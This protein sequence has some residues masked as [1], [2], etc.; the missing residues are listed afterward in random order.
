MRMLSIA[1]GSS[2]NSIYIGNDHTHILVDAGISKKRIEEGLNTIGLTVNDLS[3]IFITHEHKDHIGGVG[4]LTRKCQ[5]PVYGTKETLDYILSDTSM[6]RLDAERFMPI[7]PN[8]PLTIGD[9]I[10]DPMKISHDAANPVCY[11]FFEGDKKAAIATDLGYVT[12]ENEEKL[13]DMDVLLIEANHDIQMLQV[14]T[15]PY[16]LKQRILGKQGHLSNESCGRFLSKI[17]HD[18]LKKVYLGHLSMENNLP[19][20]AYEA[21]RLEIAMGDNPYQ[22]SD[23]EIEVAKRNEPSGVFEF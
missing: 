8:E 1:S 9:M 20:L 10:V 18:D 11:R 23:F 14:G 22:A 12:E 13:S 5:A 4:V 17:V 16:Y 3:A 21:V 7:L 6:G 2:G 15:Y 19:E